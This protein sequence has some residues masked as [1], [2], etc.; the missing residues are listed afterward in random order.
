MFILEEEVILEYIGSYFRG[1]SLSRRSYFRVESSPIGE[2]TLECM[3]VIL[4]VSI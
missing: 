3:E 1:Y 4:E 2:V